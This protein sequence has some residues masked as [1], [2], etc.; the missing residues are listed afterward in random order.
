MKGMWAEVLGHQ[1]LILPPGVKVLSTLRFGKR[2]AE[3]KPVPN[4]HVAFHP[5]HF[6]LELERGVSVAWFIK[7]FKLYFVTSLYSGR[8]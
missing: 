2:G 6:V 8:I 3:P 5:R 7:I 1:A 4:I